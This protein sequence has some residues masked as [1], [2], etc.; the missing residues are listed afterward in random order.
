MI[1]ITVQALFIPMILAQSN[2][3]ITQGQLAAIAGNSRVTLG[4][5]ERGEM[6]YEI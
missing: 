3:Q 1:D 4:K 5:L 6:V 2:K